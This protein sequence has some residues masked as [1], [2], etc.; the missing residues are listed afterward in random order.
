MIKNREFKGAC[1]GL[2]LLFLLTFEF[3]V[4]RAWIGYLEFDSKKEVAKCLQ[5][6]GELERN[7]CFVSYVEARNAKAEKSVNNYLFVIIVLVFFSAVRVYLIKKRGK[8][9]AKH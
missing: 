8:K 7:L 5:V 1:I 6:R 9:N 2:T 4:Q 3:I